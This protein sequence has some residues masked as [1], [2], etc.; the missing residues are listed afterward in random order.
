MGEKQHPEDEKLLSGL[1][2][3]KIFRQISCKL[4]MLA[5]DDKISMPGSVPRQDH[6]CRSSGIQRLG[7]QTFIF[8]PLLGEGRKIPDIFKLT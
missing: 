5:K 4:K 8:A 3:S 7:R 1:K 2:A 6:A